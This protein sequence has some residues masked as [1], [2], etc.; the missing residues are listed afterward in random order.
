M[1]TVKDVAA[2]IGVV[3]SIISLITLMTKGGRAFIKS[4][5]KK[6]TKE[7]L[8]ENEQQAKDIKEIKDTLN[9]LVDKVAAIEEESKQQCRNVIKDIYY[10]Y[11]TTK[12]IPQYDLKTVLRTYDIYTKRLGAE[13]TYATYLYHEIVD[14]WEVD[15]SNV[16]IEGDL[17]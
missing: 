1:E 8:Q 14:H 15:T 7:L 4:V 10:K 16:E 13:N 17:D 2:I 9:I 11:C 6:N 12:K 5:F 3:L